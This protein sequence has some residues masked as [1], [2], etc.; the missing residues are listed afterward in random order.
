[1][2]DFLGIGAQKSATTWLYERLQQHP[3][4]LFPAGKE[5]HFWDRNPL[6][7]PA[8]WLAPFCTAPTLKR[9]GEITPAYAILDLARIQSIQQIRP[10]LRLFISL[11]NP[12]ARAWSS[13]LMALQRAELEF[14][15]ASDQW[16]IDH[17]QS[18]GSRARGNYLRCLDNWLSVFSAEQLHVIWFEDVINTPRHVLFDL[19]RHIRVD[20]DFF[21]QLDEAELRQPVFKGLTIPL[22]PTLAAVLREIYSPMIEQL[23]QRFQRDLS[24]WSP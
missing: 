16:F 2:I 17:F 7:D 21:A 6:P 10:D 15:E 19:A 12:I 23:A 13:A 24:A 8:T 3:D 4:V 9:Q 18:R 5:M 14:D 11:R 22:R 20:P 1:M